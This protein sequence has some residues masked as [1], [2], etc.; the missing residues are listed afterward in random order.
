MFEIRVICAAPDV[1]R[2]AQAVLGSVDAT[3]VRSFPTRDGA[4]VRMYITANHRGSHADCT[5]C[6]LDGMTLWAT[7]EGREEWRP[8]TGID[9][10]DMLAAGLTHGARRREPWQRTTHR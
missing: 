6:D 4:R 7:P 3:S 2:V 9:D 8:C 1:P 10:E 5:V